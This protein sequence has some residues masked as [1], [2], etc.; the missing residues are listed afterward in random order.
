MSK[1]VVPLE[2]LL[3]A[4]QLEVYRSP[5][6]FK[7]VAA[8]RRWRKTSLGA[9]VAILKAL[10]GGIAWHIFPSYPMSQVGWR[11][12]KGL[13]RQVPGSIVNKSDR[14]VV[15]A[16]GGIAQIRSADDPDSLR[17][18]GLDQ[19]VIDEAAIVQEVVWTEAI[20]PAL[21]DKLG[22]AL[23]LGTPKG[24]NW[25]WRLWEYA[26]SSGDPTWQAFQFPTGNNPDISPE[27]IELAKSTEPLRIH[28]QELGAEFLQDGAGV[29]RGVTEAATSKHADHPVKG[30]EYI[31]GVDWGKH[32][33][34]TAVQVLDATEHALVAIDRFNEIN[35]TLQSG[36]LH[37]LYDKYRPSIIVAERNAAGEPI[38]E[39]L[40]E[41]GL[42]VVPFTTTNVSKSSAIEAL[43]L[44]IETRELRI[45]PDPVLIAELQAF[46]S[47]RLPSGLLRYAAPAGMH[48]DTVMALAMAWHG[49]G[50]SE[51]ILRWM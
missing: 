11:M 33:D 26:K 16:S 30:H 29:F 36:R 20:R 51:P 18:E 23:F 38:I 41:D 5:A 13:S 48:D 19:V 2:R 24:L 45:L 1:I 46:E 15:F 43:A 42:P 10:N 3:H 8:G 28:R 31:F 35:Y 34:F 25:F 21:T 50:S 14:M 22:D 7:V 37:A 47:E 9:L 49:I 17:G 39:R 40:L 6:R 12:L 44:A 4:G 32:N 27:E